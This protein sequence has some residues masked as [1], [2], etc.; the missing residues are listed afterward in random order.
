MST[1]LTCSAVLIPS[2][3]FEVAELTLK[4]VVDDSLD[5][6]EDVGDDKFF[7]INAITNYPLAS[8]EDAEEKEGGLGKD[9]LKMEIYISIYPTTS[10]N[11]TNAISLT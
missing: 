9:T 8:L 10:L 5:T 6:R 3:R 4:C 1:E 7:L 11:I 2:T